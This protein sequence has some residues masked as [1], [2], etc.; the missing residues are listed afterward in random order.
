MPSLNKQQVLELAQGGYIRQAEPIL[1][2]G[3]PGLGKTH[4]ATGLAAAGL[5]AGP[6]GALLQR[7][8]PGQRPARSRG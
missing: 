3:N 1:M 7:R 5:S 8:R 4:L 6:P 2:V